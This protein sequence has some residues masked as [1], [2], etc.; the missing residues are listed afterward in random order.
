MNPSLLLALCL[1]SDTQ[2]A[3]IF[4]QMLNKYYQATTLKGTIEWV[5][6]ATS[7]SLTTKATTITTV[8]MKRP[9][10][11]YL[12][13]RRDR[14][15]ERLFRAACDGKQMAYSTPKKWRD[16]PGAK[17]F[18]Y[19]PAPQDIKG[20]LDAFAPLLLDLSLPVSV[21]LYNPY[22]VQQ[23]VSRVKNVTVIG[24]TLSSGAPGWKLK[25]DYVY[26]FASPTANRPEVVIPVYVEISKNYDLLSLSWQQILQESPERKY[27]VTDSWRVHLEV[28]VPVDEKTFVIPKS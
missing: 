8:V 23:F 22:E 9:N 11:F 2:G 13:Q 26:S 16:L 14:G 3:Q 7:P 15:E 25:L 24:E 18:V 12:E 21:A 1:F 10:L 6:T 28:N 20:A 19:E 17:P 27:T 5:Q 4:S